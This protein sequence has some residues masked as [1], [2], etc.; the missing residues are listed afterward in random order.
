MPKNK[1]IGTVITLTIKAKIDSKVDLNK[2]A[3][4][5]LMT[6]SLISFAESFEKAIRDYHP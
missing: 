5:N 6:D 2:K 3:L 1:I 4:K